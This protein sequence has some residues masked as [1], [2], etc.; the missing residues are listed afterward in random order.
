MKKQKTEGLLINGSFRQAGVTVYTRAGKTIV[1]SS[2]SQQP[3]RRT[4]AQFEVRMR[5]KHN[6]ALWAALKECG[7]VHFYGEGNAYSRFRSLAFH[8]PVV[9]SKK[10]QKFTLLMPGIP[11]SEGSL[12]SFKQQL[13]TVSGTPALVTNLTKEEL[14]ESTRLLLFQAEQQDGKNP[15]CLFTVSEVKKSDLVAV[16]KG[17]ALVDEKFGDDTKGWALVRMIRKSYQ[18]NDEMPWRVSTQTIVTR[19]NLWKQYTT[20]K[21]QKEC[22]ESYGGVKEK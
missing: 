19:C 20:D 9:Y 18:T 1:R 11:V 22:L 10:N 15:R 14:G 2:H 16:K 8:L 6:A 17:Y 7:E 5:T 21:A 12:P 3:Q 13:D 4:P